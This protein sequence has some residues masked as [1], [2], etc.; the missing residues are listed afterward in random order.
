MQGVRTVQGEGLVEDL[1]VRSDLL[2]WWLSK[3]DCYGN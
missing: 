2:E 1:E 3:E